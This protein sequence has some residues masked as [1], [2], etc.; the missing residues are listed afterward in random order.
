[1]TLIRCGG[2]FEGSSVLHWPAGADS[3]GALFTGD[4]LYVV[5]DRR[6]VSFMYSFPN[7][8]PLPVRE[9][10]RIAAIVEPYAFDR[11]Y[12]AWWDRVVMDGG[13]TAVSRSADRY[14]QALQG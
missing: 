7:L 9:V 12:S 8:I 10:L 3:K 6:Y 1:M 13:K 11:I 2:H 4:T 5:S 14:I